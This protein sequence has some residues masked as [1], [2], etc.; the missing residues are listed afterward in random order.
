MY[1][2]D[3]EKYHTTE[4]FG[5]YSFLIGGSFWLGIRLSFSMQSFPVPDGKEYNNN[6]RKFLDMRLVSC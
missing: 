4:N 2:D 6:N 3:K 5:V 1:I